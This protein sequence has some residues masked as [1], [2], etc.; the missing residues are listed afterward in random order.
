MAKHGPVTGLNDRAPRSRA[1]P[2]KRRGHRYFAFL[3]YS[4]RDEELADW[5]H[6]ELEDFHVPSRW[7]AR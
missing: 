7:P 6:Q 2:R 1:K 4:H 3:S 5:L